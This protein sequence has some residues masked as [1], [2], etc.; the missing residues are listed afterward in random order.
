MGTAWGLGDSFQLEVSKGEEYSP[1][2][3][4]PV[5]ARE[6]C[7]PLRCGVGERESVTGEENGMSWM[8]SRVWDMG[9]LLVPGSVQY[10][11]LH[12]P[13]PQTP[14]PLVSGAWPWLWEGLTL[15]PC[16]LCTCVH[17]ATATGLR[18]RLVGVC[19]QPG[20]SESLTRIFQTKSGN[21]SVPL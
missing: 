17:P 10:V 5:P 11:P 14:S 2:S 16:S 6:G 4:F 18:R 7:H 15:V 13:P 8:W 20:Q 19:P 9:R 1:T 21:Q 12:H 3:R